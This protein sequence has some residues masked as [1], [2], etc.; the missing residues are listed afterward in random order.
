MMQHIGE[1]M[2]LAC[3]RWRPRQRALLNAPFNDVTIETRSLPTLARCYPRSF[4]FYVAHP[5]RS[6]Q[7]CNG[8]QSNDTVTMLPS[9]KPM[10]AGTA[11]L[12]SCRKMVEAKCDKNLTLFEEPLPCFCLRAC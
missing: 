5:I 1:H 11:P 8:S 4:T 7:R 3:W 9:F 6:I 12:F 2:R 10:Y